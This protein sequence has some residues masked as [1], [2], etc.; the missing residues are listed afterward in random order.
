MKR[1]SS[2]VRCLAVPKVLPHYVAIAIRRTGAT[3]GRWITHVENIYFPI[4]Q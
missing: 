4:L 1:P 3:L 2:S